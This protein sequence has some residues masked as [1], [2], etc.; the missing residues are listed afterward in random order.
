MGNGCG[1]PRS[2]QRAQAAT[3]LV[4][5]ALHFVHLRSRRRLLHFAECLGDLAFL[6]A[7]LGAGTGQAALRLQKLRRAM[8]RQQRFVGNVDTRRSIPASS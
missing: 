6:Q 8:S 7:A 3:Q 1:Y 4:N 5:L 2:F